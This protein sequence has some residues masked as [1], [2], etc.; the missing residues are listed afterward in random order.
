MFPEQLKMNPPLRWDT[1]KI[2]KNAFVSVSFFK[3]HTSP[4]TLLSVLSMLHITSLSFIDRK[5]RK[6]KLWMR[7]IR[8]GHRFLHV[9][10]MTHVHF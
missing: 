1:V 5:T 2:E 10:I 4:E 9:L 8:I 6:L 3:Q 7:E